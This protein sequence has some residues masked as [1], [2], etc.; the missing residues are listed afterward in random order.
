MENHVKV[1]IFLNTLELFGTNILRT[2]FTSIKD[3]KITN[4]HSKTSH[5]NEKFSKANTIFVTQKNT[6]IKGISLHNYIIVVRL[7]YLHKK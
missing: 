2:N 5:L 1:W 6:V 4:Q 7:L 3:I